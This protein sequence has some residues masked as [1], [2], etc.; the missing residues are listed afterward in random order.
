MTT[1]PNMPNKETILVVDDEFGPR[2]SLR[3]ILSLLY[4]VHT[5]AAG[6]EALRFIHDHYVDLVTL[7]LNMPGRSGFGVLKE[8]KDF[9]PDLEVIIITA[10]GSLQNAKEA[11]RLGAEDFIPKPFNVA[12]IMTIV[13]KSL[14]RRKNNLKIKHLTDRIKTIRSPAHKNEDICGRGWGED[15][16]SQDPEKSTIR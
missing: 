3:V 2:E 6:E 8:I 15:T 5:V 13:G 14:E 11:I 9:R 12:D 1:G 4:E 10:Y 7:D 16:D